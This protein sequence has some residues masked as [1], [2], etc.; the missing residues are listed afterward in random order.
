M[1]YFFLDIKG[2]APAP[3]QS[4]LMLVGCQEM[5]SWQECGYK[6]DFTFWEGGAYVIQL[7]CESKMS[8]LF[9]TMFF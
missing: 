5:G 6:L 7:K 2:K 4:L 1:S 8:F 3:Y 9:N